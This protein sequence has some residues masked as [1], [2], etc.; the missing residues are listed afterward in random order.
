[1]RHLTL[2]YLAVAFLVFGPGCGTQGTHPPTPT[3]PPISPPPI[4]P[5]LPPSKPITPPKSPQDL[6][7]AIVNNE[8]TKHN[9]TPLVDSHQLDLAA[10]EYT[11]LMESRST[12]SHDLGGGFANRVRLWNIGGFTAAG[13]NI[14]MGQQ[15]PEAAVTAWMNSAGHRA[16]IL[17]NTYNTTGVGAV[18]GG[19]GRWWWCQE[20]VTKTSSPH[21]PLSPI[22]HAPGPLRTD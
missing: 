17:N 21:L 12:L 18:K 1:M 4:L 13:E 15:T 20:F 9:L 11:H 10:Q 8:R 3:P 7:V 6:V 14:A 22:L 5:P 16:N 19:N 2:Y